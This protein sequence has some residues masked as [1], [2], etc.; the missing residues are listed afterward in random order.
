MSGPATNEARPHVNNCLLHDAGTMCSLDRVKTMQSTASPPAIASSQQWPVGLSQHV[1]RLRARIS[2][3]EPQGNSFVTTSKTQ[4]IDPLLS[5][6]NTRA[7]PRC[8]QTH[9]FAQPKM[10]TAQLASFQHLS[11]AA[12]SIL[13]AILSSKMRIMGSGQHTARPR[14]V[15]I[16]LPPL[17]LPTYLCKPR[18]RRSERSA[19]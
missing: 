14:P 4:I 2:S 8:N 16:F 11:I 18:L 9:P 19:W 17:L 6:E 7:R 3:C 12:P 13:S 5:I 1:E 15:D 10:P